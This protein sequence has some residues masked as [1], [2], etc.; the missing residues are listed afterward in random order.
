MFYY[1]LTC[2]NDLMFLVYAVKYDKNRVD[3]VR[4]K[5][6]S[7]WQK[8]LLNQFHDVLPGSCI[9]QVGYIPFIVLY[10][11]GND[12]IQYVH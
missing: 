3:L 5:I 8:F 6:L 4:A 7:L 12:C 10:M 9:E 2:V 1:I 11:H